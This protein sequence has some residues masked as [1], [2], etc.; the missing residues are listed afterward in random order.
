MLAKGIQMR[1]H[2]MVL[3]NEADESSW[4]RGSVWVD[5]EAIQLT[6]GQAEAGRWPSAQVSMTE[7][8]S[9]RFWLTV[10]GGRVLFAPD[11]VGAFEDEVRAQ[12]LRS[13]LAAPT[14]APAAF[15]PTAPGAPSPAVASPKSPGVAAVLSA[16]W[17]GLGQI[18]N[19]EILLGLLLM[20]VQFIN[21]LLFAILIGFV[22]GPIVWVLAIVQAY[23][24]AERYNQTHGLVY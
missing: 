12:A 19:G 18:Y 2:G 20:F 17:T 4:Q 15:A 22:T 3:L 24:G 16:V 11:D 9:G 8:G 14:P 7:E 5:G 23:R 6:V 1:H 21:V 10:Q 13:R